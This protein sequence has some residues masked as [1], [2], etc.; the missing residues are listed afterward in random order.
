MHISKSNDNKPTTM[1]N[2][3]TVN[4]KKYTLTQPR[5]NHL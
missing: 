3:T 2:Q 5:K 1:Q 4:A